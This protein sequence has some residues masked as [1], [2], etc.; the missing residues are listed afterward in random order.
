MNRITGCLSRPADVT[1]APQSQVAATS[2]RPSRLA[3]LF[4]GLRLRRPPTAFGDLPQ[5][6]LVTVA[7]KLVQGPRADVADLVR[8]AAVNKAL[9]SA[10][11]TDPQT[12]RRL[13]LAPIEHSAR[14]LMA[15]LL[16]VGPDPYEASLCLPVLDRLKVHEQTALVRSL[17]VPER[18]GQPLW[19]PHPFRVL[20]ARLPDLAR[21]AQVELLRRVALQ[22]STPDIAPAI[23]GMGVGVAHLHAGDID[24]LLDRAAGIHDDD[25][26]AVA[27]C[28]LCAG[29]GPMND[30]QRL[31]LWDGVMAL[32]SSLGRAL[33]G[34]GAQLKH[35]DDSQRNQV[36][37]RAM[38]LNDS[39]ESAMALSGLAA[40]M[41]VLTQAQRQALVR[42]GLC[43]PNGLTGER[44]A[45]VCAFAASVEHLATN[46][47]IEL[48]AEILGPGAAS[49]EDRSA[50]LAALGAHLGHLTPGQQAQL[51]EAAAAWPDHA[52]AKALT[53][54]AAALPHLAPAHRR[55]V[56]DLALTMKQ[57]PCA[58]RAIGALGPH[59]KHL[60]DGLRDALVTHALQLLGRLDSHLIA[61]PEDV[62][63]LA[64][65]LG[66]GMAALRAE[67]RS[68]L[69][70]T[71]LGT[72]SRWAYPQ[73]PKLA[74]AIG[75]LAAGQQHL[76]DPEHAALVQAAAHLQTDLRL[77]VGSQV[78]S[79]WEGTQ[80]QAVA[81][82]GLV[83][84]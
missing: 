61:S 53:G 17:T 15:C 59:L 4:S 40:S 14:C 73:L 51:L 41:D 65:G 28:G 63:A 80:A 49:I 37:V 42:R 74:A 79:S 83:K 3:G 67:Q 27:L 32:E 76:S 58:A 23:G 29:F 26:R 12:L 43:L 64:A 66:A 38:Q 50:A 71:A 11:T 82:F 21:P 1:P 75:G 33:Q 46:Q 9:R 5:E 6:V 72:R 35:L 52:R 8:T 84:A 78:L 30:P 62:Q 48:I 36:F 25:A 45:M 2:G 70:A 60:D 39:L 18:P 10:L 20:A 81:L 54:L 7:E 31:R 69:V 16:P 57:D 47:R 22:H 56:A 44:Q 19:T 77:A 24:L 13:R 55:G 34:L 68:A